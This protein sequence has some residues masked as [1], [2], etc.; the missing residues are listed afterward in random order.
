MNPSD[1]EESTFGGFGRIRDSSGSSRNKVA[2]ET[3]V[4]YRGEGIVSLAEDDLQESNSLT[5]SR[6][7]DLIRFP[8]QL[9]FL[10]HL[11]LTV[12]HGL[13][14]GRVFLDTPLHTQFFHPVTN[15]VHLGDVRGAVVG[16][17]KNQLLWVHTRREEVGLHV[18]F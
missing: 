2:F 16:E 8:L 18:G 3:E 5:D 1:K 6:L 14:Y 11:E 4:E 17:V 12:Y 10:R 15:K 13:E 7:V 9:A